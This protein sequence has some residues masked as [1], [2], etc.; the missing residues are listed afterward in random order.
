MTS[1]EMLVVD[2]CAAD[3]ASIRVA[4]EQSKLPMKLSFASSGDSAL[5]ML[6]GEVDGAPP[7]RPHLLFID[8]N[9]P[10]ISGLE[11][12]RILKT[13][14]DLLSIP[15]IMFSGSEQDSDID[16]AYLN[17]ANGYIKKPSD[18]AGLNAM[19]GV[20]G[21]LLTSVLAFPSR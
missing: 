18:K 9:M 14:N 11:L 15:V 16:E 12:L 13:D 1:V 4:F 5:T 17:H 19:A 2:D 8:V 7:C 21:Q 3:R 10:G 20:V 6:R